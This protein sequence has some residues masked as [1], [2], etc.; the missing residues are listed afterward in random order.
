MAKR[1]RRSLKAMHKRLLAIRNLMS[2]PRT[3]LT[4]LEREYVRLEDAIVER[5]RE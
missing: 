3:N 5:E 4:R 2:K 1:R